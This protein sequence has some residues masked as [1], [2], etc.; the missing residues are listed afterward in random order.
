MLQI[1]AGE[2]GPTHQQMAL[3]ILPAGADPD[4]APKA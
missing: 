1:A 2:E 4:A 3:R